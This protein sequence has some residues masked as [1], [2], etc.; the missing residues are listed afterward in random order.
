MKYILFLLF[1]LSF[2]FVSAADDVFETFSDLLG[3]PVTAITNFVSGS[4]DATGE[5]YSRFLIFL[6]VFSVA[7]IGMLKVKNSLNMTQKGPFT[8]IAIAFGFIGAF[9]MPQSYVQTLFQT[10]GLFVA[11]LMLLAILGLLV[12]TFLNLGEH[13]NNTGI[14]FIFITLGYILTVVIDEM[15]R[16]YPVQ[17]AYFGSIGAV[18]SLLTAVLLIG[19][20]WYLFKFVGS[21]FKRG[22]SDREDLLDPAVNLAKKEVNAH[23]KRK[24][25]KKETWKKELQTALA[26]YF[27]LKSRTGKL[28]NQ[29]ILD[30]LLDSSIKLSTRKNNLAKLIKANWFLYNFLPKNNPFDSHVNLYPVFENLLHMRVNVMGCLNLFSE[31]LNSSV[32]D[33]TEEVLLRNSTLSKSQIN[34]LFTNFD[35]A[36]DGLNQM[37]ENEPD[38]SHSHGERTSHESPSHGESPSHE[39]T[40]PAGVSHESPSHGESPSHEST[41]SAESDKEVLKSMEKE[42]L[43]GL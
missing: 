11:L 17:R 31:N 30:Y 10:Y 34:K 29:P 6:I 16:T 13:K 40:T 1:L 41:T 37:L 3:A 32:T 14:R 27:R 15:I 19:V 5:F 2:N 28:K 25:K 26:R 23:N 38:E 9:A 4:G 33:V 43:G 8:T 42:F 12:F 35:N 22:E 7:Y 36:L 18:V 21:L 20:F 24:D 39:S